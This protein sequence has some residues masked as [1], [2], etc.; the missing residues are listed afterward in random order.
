MN[1]PLRVGVFVYRFP[2][3]SETFIVTKVLGLLEQGVDVRIFTVTPSAAWDQFT[4]LRGRDDV[5]RRVR[6][7]PPLRPLWKVLTV[8][9]AAVLRVA[10]TRPRAFLRFLAHNWRVRRVNYLGF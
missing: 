2:T 10:V 3:P 9:V 7:A 5:R 4:V 8:G 1:R 6:S